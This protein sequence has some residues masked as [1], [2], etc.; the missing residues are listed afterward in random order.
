MKKIRYILEACCS[1]FVYYVFKILPPAAASAFGGWLTGLIGPKLAASRKAERNLNTVFPDSTTKDRQKIIKG[2][3]NNFGRVIAE[4]PH[5][6][7]I[8][9]QYVEV[10]GEDILKSVLKDEKGAIFI[11][12]HQGNWELNVP[13]LL[14][15]YNIEADLTYRAMN[16]PYVNTLICKARNIDGRLQAHPKSRESGRKLLSTLRRHGYLGILIDQKY[17]NGLNVPF[18]GFPAM[19]NPVA[20]QLAQKMGVPLVF[21]QNER[22]KGCNFRLTVHEPIHLFNTDGTP[23]PL[24]N[25]IENAHSLLEKTIRAQPEQWIWIH[26]RWKA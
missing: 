20:F 14:M 25:I 21:V 18:F 22:L 9:G 7:T 13:T 5:L 23:L 6:K 19:T 11:G 24:E 3:W 8:S 17:N 16:N 2:M 26:K 12:A 4:Y 10:V 1:Y 15:K